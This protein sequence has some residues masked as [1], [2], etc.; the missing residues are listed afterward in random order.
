MSSR[1]LIALA[2]TTLLLC[3]GL[4]AVAGA[5]SVVTINCAVPSGNCSGKKLFG[6]HI[7][8]RDLTRTRWVKS[9]LLMASFR[10]SDLY[11]SNF[12]GA[13]LRRADLSH[14]N[15]T[16]A[17]FR[18]ANLTQADLSDADF[19]GS[20]FRHADARGAKLINARFDET[21]L[22]GANFEGAVFIS[23]TFNR[24]KLCHTIQPN[25]EERDDNC[26]GNGSGGGSPQGR[27][28][29]PGGK[30]K[31]KGKG[32]GGS[33]G[34]KGSKDDDGDSSSGGDGDVIVGDL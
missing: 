2:A 4:S 23:T 3:L 9:G 19:Y 8:K 25:G 30:D 18:H 11:G 14:G 31:D 22:T 20:S 1:N 10:F 24:V 13:N 32:N 27:C 34:S 15:R 5:G 33:G 26:P 21:D 7:W 29:F 17:N 6:K 12:R 28:C 16:K